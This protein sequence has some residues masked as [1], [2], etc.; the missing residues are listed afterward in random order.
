M[1]EIVYKPAKP[2]Y[3]RW[4]EEEGIPIFDGLAV[5]DVTELPRK[6]WARMGGNG[7]YIQLKGGGGVTGMY[8]VE[9]PPGGALNPERHMYDELLYAL[10]GHGSTEVWYD[11]MRK[12][13]FEWSEGSLFAPPLNTWHRH[14][15]GSRE[16]AFLLAVTT[17][18]IIIDFFRDPEFVFNNSY[19]FK[20]RYN[21]ED[22]YFAMSDRRYK[23]TRTSM[24]D[25]NFIADARVATVENAPYKVAEGG[26]TC[27][28]MA[29]NSLI[30]HISE[31]PSGIY[32]KAHYHA[33]G[34]ILLVV[35]SYGYIYMWPKELGVRP[36]Q[37]GKGDQVVK[38]NWKPGSIYS[39]PDGWF[40]TH[41]NSGPEP[42][43]HVALRLGSRK[44][45]TTIH[46]ASTR[47]NREGPTTSLREGGT[48]IEYED[49]DPEIR[50]V[51][52]EECKTNRVENRMPPITYRND[53][54]IVD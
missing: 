24:W 42:A 27:F 50:R 30:G 3:V 51:F 32:H 14:Y 44:N 41:L 26:I 29:D 5:E 43:R 33:A 35:R 48:L 25:T 31:W 15:N 38:C 47:N 13:A 49:E 36:F 52:L 8:V 39:P 4:M 34:A 45:P 54:L 17:A 37:N 40:H 1:E 53:P 9:I 11:G 10:K 21:G 7:S 22:S 2:A 16:P 6:P 12:Q 23:A 19:A 20:S 18:P 46:D 28:E